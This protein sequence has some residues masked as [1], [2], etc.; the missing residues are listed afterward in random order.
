M[1]R[2][3]VFALA[4]CSLALAEGDARLD[5]RV[6]DADTGL[7]IAG[8]EV[9]LGDWTAGGWA[10][11]ATAHS[12]EKGGFSFDVG[13]LVSSGTVLASAEG[14]QTRRLTW[15]GVLSA[16]GPY[17]ITIALD[18]GV[19]LSGTV[20]GQDGAPVPDATVS[21]EV[22]SSDPTTTKTDSRGAFRIGGVPW[23]PVTLEAS[24]PGRGLRRIEGVFPSQLS[25]PIRLQPCPTLALKLVG[26]GTLKP[27]AG[28]EILAEVFLG[29]RTWRG[30]RVRSDDLGRADLAL[31]P[32]SRV[33]LSFWCQGHWFV[34]AELGG[35]IPA[36]LTVPIPPVRAEVNLR[37]Q[38][39]LRDPDAPVAR[40]VVRA[41]LEK[42]TPCGQCLCEAWYS[43]P[44][45]T[46]QADG[47]FAMEG[48]PAG[49]VSLEVHD[50]DAP[51]VLTDSPY[52]FDLI[53]GTDPEPVTL[54]VKKRPEPDP[55]LVHALVLMPNGDPA[56]AASVCVETRTGQGGQ[57]IGGCTCLDGTFEVA[58][59]WERGHEVTL[60]AWVPGIGSGKAG[61]YRRRE[62]LVSAPLKIEIGCGASISGRVLDADGKPVARCAVCL[63]AKRAAGPACRSWVGSLPTNGGNVYSDDQGGFCFRQ[64]PAGD[65]WVSAWHPDFRGG[66]FRV[67]R[68]EGGEAIEL[69]PFH[70][71]PGGYFVGTVVTAD[72]LPAKGV[73]LS[74][75]ST[76][77][78]SWWGTSQTD[79]EGR[80]A[81]LYLPA[82]AKA[83][84]VSAIVD[85]EWISVVEGLPVPRRDVRVKLPPAQGR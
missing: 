12:D 58:L 17:R 75:T 52:E 9:V 50:Q 10:T 56:P 37:G 35:T 61:P 46:T 82:R 28:V 4:C 65:M 3:A 62:D 80:F 57:T 34:R 30:P 39:R 68:I 48:L 1:T 14:H 67:A 51:A 20:L 32:A 41:S 72:G 64:V 22:D 18:S 63:G 45:A 53:A 8:A 25:E 40:V 84:S 83:V 2:L 19:E 81:F 23:R 77:S 11:A 42:A 71:H 66:Q 33:S 13:P 49:H 70:L 79:E 69:E 54:L 38:V 24:A 7:A 16:K 27:L 36:E 55:C 73:S 5:G 60:Y 76:Q 15:D 74:A 47:T 43:P 29:N 26:E 85:R 59:G 78:S 31:P 44:T 6:V 21:I